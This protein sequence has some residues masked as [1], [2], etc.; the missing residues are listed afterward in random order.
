[1]V[2]LEE[3]RMSIEIAIYQVWLKDGVGFT[4]AG[5]LLAAELKEFLESFK[6]CHVIGS[7]VIVL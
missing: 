5:T 7:S 6:N 4:P 1:M 2:L 3:L